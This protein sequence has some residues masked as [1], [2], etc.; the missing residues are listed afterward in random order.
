MR[1]GGVH[2]G[3]QRRRRLKQARRGRR[4]GVNTENLC[5]RWIFLRAFLQ[6]FQPP[7]QPLH[8]GRLAINRSAN[9]VGK[10]ALAQI[11]TDAGQ[12]FCDLRGGGA[13]RF[14]R[15]L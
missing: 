7:R 15:R 11:P 8:S 6:A 5:W 13:E 12:T 10:S 1:Q 2:A 4:R 9:I 3:A 14:L